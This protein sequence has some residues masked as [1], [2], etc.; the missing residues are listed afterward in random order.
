MCI[1]DRED[2]EVTEKLPQE[3]I[4]DTGKIPEELPE[5]ETTTTNEPED[6][7]VERRVEA[8]LSQ[9]EEVLDEEIKK[10]IDERVEKMFHPEEQEEE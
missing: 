6:K 8:I 10:K 1:R 9:K 2:T 4:Q 7:E 5:I 3:N